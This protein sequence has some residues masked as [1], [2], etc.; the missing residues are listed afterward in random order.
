MKIISAEKFSKK[1]I[2]EFDKSDVD[3]VR[4]IIS[5]VKRLGDKAIIKYTK[6]FDKVRLTKDK[7]RVKESEILSSLS[8]LDKELERAIG[9][10]KG[11][12]EI[13]SKYQL[14]SIK[15]FTIT[16]SK[17][18]FC[19]QRIIPIERV[20][21]YMPA[22]NFPLIS[23]LIMCAVPA[24]IAGVKEIVVVSPPR[25]NGDIHTAILQ[26]AALIGVNEVYRIGGFKP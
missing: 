9:I 22:G 1:R 12:L 26:T 15:D 25:D 8:H 17:G 23:T 20:G 10:A 18:V 24:Q 4:R 7:L 3:R 5:D 2:K 14:K 13:F 19:S 21:I 11:N 6:K 16:I